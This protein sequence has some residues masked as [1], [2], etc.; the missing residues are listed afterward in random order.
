MI[1]LCYELSFITDG[2]ST[3]DA[4]VSSYLCRVINWQPISFKDLDC[5]VSLHLLFTSNRK[6]K[7]LHSSFH[8][9]STTKPVT[10]Q[11]SLTSDCHIRTPYHYGNVHMGMPRYWQFWCK[12]LFNPAEPNALHTSMNILSF[13]TY[14]HWCFWWFEWMCAVAHEMTCL[15]VFQFYLHPTKVIWK[16]SMKD[17]QW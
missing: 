7:T 5:S 13:M 14:C 3:P 10:G 9:L 6:E 16:T 17:V 11:S 15:F 12:V 8:G 2:S 4:W 1:H